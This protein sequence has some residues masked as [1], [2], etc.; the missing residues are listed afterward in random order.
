MEKKWSNCH[1]NLCEKK[2]NEGRAETQKHASVL[3]VEMAL[4]AM[5]VHTE[6]EKDS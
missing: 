6:K 3:K 1:M 2:N 5:L 4:L